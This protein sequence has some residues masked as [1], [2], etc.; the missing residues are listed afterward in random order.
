M[1]SRA[2]V[3][4]ARVIASVAA[5]I[6]MP[7]LTADPPREV[8]GSA[9]VFA[10]PGVTLAWGILRGASDATTTVVVRIAADPA[11][12]ASVA[13]AGRDPFTQQ[14]KPLL[15]ATPTTRA[16][17]LRVPRAHFA[18]FPRTELLLYDSAA[19]AQSATP[20]LVVF[21]LGVPDTTP[22]L[23]SEAALETYL[24]ERVAGARGRPGDKPP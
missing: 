20:K 12:Y 9:D 8:H 2:V 5:A 13:V 19:P 17:D 23:A 22:E 3:A 24:A 21:Y 16:I 18:E 15:P 1:T 4:L 11:Q 6:A 10:A 7:A 14:A